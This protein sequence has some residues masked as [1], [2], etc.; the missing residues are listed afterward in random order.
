[1]NPKFNLDNYAKYLD[2]LIPTAYHSKID[3]KKIQKSVSDEFSFIEKLLYSREYAEKFQLNC[4]VENTN[5]ADYHAKFIEIEG[6]EMVISIRFLN[7]N[8]A[9]PYILIEYYSCSTVH[10]FSKFSFIKSEILDQYKVFDVKKIRMT[11]RT[12]DIDDFNHLEPKGDLLMY[13]API[14][15]IL[16]KEL[17]TIPQLEVI[18]INEFSETDYEVYLREYE[19][20]QRDYPH[21]TSV[22]PEP[23][24]TLNQYCASDYGFKAYIDGEWAGFAL[25]A[26]FSEFFF[27]GYLVWD[28]IIFEKF[29]GINLSTY[30]Q[31]IGFKNYVEDKSGFI[32]GNIQSENIGSRKTAEKSGR[33]NLISSYFFE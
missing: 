21:L 19:K 14:S 20:F 27:Y 6:I 29:R 3:R 17:D 23:L 25:Y 9:F 32:Y 4:W 30:I 13:S 22:S 1:M 7:R 2:Q 26:N 15:E 28:K 5:A 16:E 11:L 31:N 33:E 12:E 8:V 24:K 18:Q 10:F